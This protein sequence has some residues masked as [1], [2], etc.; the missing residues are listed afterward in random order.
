MRKFCGDIGF[1]PSDLLSPQQL[2]E[3]K[4]TP[5]RFFLEEVG[6]EDHLTFLEMLGNFSF[7]GYF[8]EE[9]IKFAFEF[10]FQELKLPLD[11]ALFTVFEGDKD[12]PE[13]KESI[14]IWK[15][16]GIGSDKI[17]KYGRADNFWGPTGEE[18]P[19]GPTTEI[20]IRGVRCV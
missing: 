3:R 8:K 5:E 16:L 10:I 14:S 17:K 2:M 6:D 9:T 7:G 18:G 4:S 15:K 12:I 19:C 13:D 1:R 20:H 11:N